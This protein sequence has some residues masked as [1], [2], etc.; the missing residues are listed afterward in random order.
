MI[1]RNA[2]A[3]IA[4]IA[5]VLAAVSAGLVVVSEKWPKEK[6]GGRDNSG[7]EGGGAERIQ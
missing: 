2:V 1:M 4:Y 6:P 5:A 3:W 7:N